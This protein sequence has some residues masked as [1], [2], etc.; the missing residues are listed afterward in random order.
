MKV[1]GNITITSTGLS[2]PKVMTLLLSDGSRHK[3]VIKY[4]SDDLRQDAIME[5]VFQQVNKI[6]GKDVEMRRSDLHMRTYNVVPLG[7]K[8]GLI[9]FVNNSLS[10]H[11]ILTDIHKDDNYSWL[12]AR[13]SMKDVQSKSDKERILTYLD[14]TKK[15]SPKFRNFF[16]NS[17]IDANGWICA[18]RKYT[19]GV[20]TSSMVGYILGLGDR[21]LNNILIDTTTGEPIHIDL[22]IAFD[23]GRLLKIPELVPFRLTRDIIDGFGITG[24]EGI[25]RRTCEQ[26]LNV[27]SRDSEK[28]MCVLNILKWDPLY[29]WAVSPFKKHKY[30]YDD[31][32]EGHMTTATNNSKVIER[33]LTPKLDSD[34]NQQSYRALKG[35]Q[36]KLDRNGLTIE[37]TVEKLIQEAVDESNLALIFNGWSPFY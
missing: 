17:F 4:G 1:I 20:A 12:E 2:L 28:V 24:V 7:P 30:M 21:H 27:L 36:E 34:E 14:I 9:E 35:V 29:S 11:S 19:K 33:K 3:V 22:G 23:Q 10:L 6:F 32:L 37:A 15:I 18:K 25:F 16:F 26:V 5:Q 8:A 31:N 13:R